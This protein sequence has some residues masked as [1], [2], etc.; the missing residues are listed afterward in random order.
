MPY[1]LSADETV[2]DGLR[3]VAR[4]QLET[5]VDR[6]DSATQEEPVTAIH[7][8]RKA[9]KKERSVLRSVRGAMRPRERRREDAR[10]RDSGRRLGRARDADV[11]LSALSDTAEHFTGQVPEA[12]VNAVREQLVQE[13]QV[14]RAGL[15]VDEVPRRVADELREALLAVEEW[16]LRGGGWSLIRPGIDRE[17]RRGR[18]AMRRAAKNPTPERMHDW[19]KRSKDLWYQLRLLGEL[20]PDTIKGQAKDAHRLAD[21]LGDQHDLVLLE[22]AVRRLDPDLPVDTEPLIA[23]IQHRGEQLGGEAFSLGERVYAE[24][25]KAYLRRLRRYWRAWRAEAKAAAAERPEVLAEVTRH[26]STA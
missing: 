19:R 12:T 18:K 14:A 23:L 21:L 8:A 26:A 5:A 25:P 24:K 15:A 1:R 20:A 13:Q 10:L 2:T 22:A 3:R 17:Y 9:L 16:K 6:L 4:E 7:D 11:L